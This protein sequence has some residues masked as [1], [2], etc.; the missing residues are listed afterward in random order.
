MDKW[1]VLQY[2][3]PFIL[4]LRSAIVLVPVPFPAPGTEHS[5]YDYTII[6]FDY[7]KN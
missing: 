3:K 4:H 7:F 1:V 6:G 2:V 5:Q